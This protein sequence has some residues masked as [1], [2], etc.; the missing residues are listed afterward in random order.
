MESAGEKLQQCYNQTPRNSYTHQQ[1]YNMKATGNHCGF[2]WGEFID[3]QKPIAYEAFHNGTLVQT[4]KKCRRLSDPKK[5]D[6]FHVGCAGRKNCND[7][8][9]IC[10]DNPVLQYFE[11][12]QVSDS[13]L[14]SFGSFYIVNISFFL[15]IIFFGVYR[16]NKS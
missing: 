11:M 10:Y 16:R 12:C 4:F 15:L 9:R 7:L 5:C 8:K 2:E 13:F 1:Q 14:P 6:L 3:F